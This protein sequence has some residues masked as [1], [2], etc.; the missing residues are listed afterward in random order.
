MPIL[1]LRPLRRAA[2]AV[3]ALVLSAAAHAE[4]PDHPIRLVLPYASGGGADTVGRPMAVALSKQ[5]GATVIVDNR[6]G[7]S[8]GIAMSLV[9]HA[10]PD[11]Y[12]LALALTAQ[13][14]IN[15]GLVK[16]L[17][18][19]PVK[20]FEPISLL[21]QAPYFLA[22]SPSLGVKTLPEFIA[23]V[24]KN[25]GK[26]SYG[27]S[28]TGSGLHL[29]MELLKSM[30]GLDMEHIP[31]QGASPAYT[32]LMGGRLQAVFAGFGSGGSFLQAG[33][34]VA[35]GV[36]TAQRSPAHP[37]VP[38]IAEAGVPGYQSY[39]WYALLAPK[40]TPQPILDKLQRAAVAALKDPEVQKLFMV[41]GVQPIGS[42][43]QELSA[44]MRKETVKWREVIQRA[45]IEP[46]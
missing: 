21:A 32:D 20:D 35:L 30:A 9:A 6:G 22:V 7:A 44:F 13:A 31:Y 33:K 18:Y 3:A 17:S 2:V 12:T 10:K 34:M 1:N 46:E 8:G 40:G 26:F 15:P 29:S 38:T 5:L 45:G 43:P 37:E 16:R 28:G 14:A 19:D 24:R 39:V 36:T 41:D 4:Y 25:P 23:L 42:S 27:S 11:G